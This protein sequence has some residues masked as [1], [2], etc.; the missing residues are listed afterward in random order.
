M[1]S[2]VILCYM[3]VMHK[4]ILFREDLPLPREMSWNESPDPRER[5]L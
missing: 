3:Q 2:T 5:M 1:S 4:R